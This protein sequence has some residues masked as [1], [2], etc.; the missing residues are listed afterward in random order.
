MARSARYWVLHFRDRPPHHILFEPAQAKRLDQ[1][2]QVFQLLKEFVEVL[3]RQDSAFDLSRDL[4]RNTVLIQSGQQRI[5]EQVFQL[6]SEEAEV[7]GFV[8]PFLEHVRMDLVD[9]HDVPRQ[10]EAHHVLH[11]LQA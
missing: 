4:R 9:G 7:S 11:E 5:Q 8:A 2:C 1:G 3:R 10:A 6:L